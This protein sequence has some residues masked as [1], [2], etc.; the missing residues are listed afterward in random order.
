MTKETLSM[1]SDWPEIRRRLT[2][3]ACDS[4]QST[5][6]NCAEMAK[7]LQ[8]IAHLEQWVYVFLSGM[9]VAILWMLWEWVGEKLRSIEPPEPPPDHAPYRRRRAARGGRHDL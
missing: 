4:A 6:A 1:L 2:E 9:A 7:Q 3:R 5:P 8:E